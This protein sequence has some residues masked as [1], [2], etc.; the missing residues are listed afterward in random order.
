M[1][2]LISNP[3]IQ[4]DQIISLFIDICK[5]GLDE[6][7]INFLKVTAENGRLELIPQIADS[8]EIKR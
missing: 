4:R 5:D 8:F 1:N 3:E 6:K 2:D 7:G